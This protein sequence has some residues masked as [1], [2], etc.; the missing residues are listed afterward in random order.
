MGNFVCF[1]KTRKEKC[2]PGDCI[3]LKGVILALALPW[4]FVRV[5]GFY[6]REWRSLP[7]LALIPEGC[8]LKEKRDAGIC[9]IFC[10][11]AGGIL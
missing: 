4:E 11:E 10:K 1:V 9:P 8:W 2:E 7:I 6:N 3:F 5:I